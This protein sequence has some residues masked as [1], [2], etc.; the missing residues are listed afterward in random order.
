[1]NLEAD[2]GGARDEAGLS[3]ETRTWT[4]RLERVSIPFFSALEPFLLTLGMI[5]G[6][7][8]VLVGSSCY[9]SLSKSLS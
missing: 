3:T 6:V 4:G 7:G 2:I 8:A 9:A 1:M 5:R